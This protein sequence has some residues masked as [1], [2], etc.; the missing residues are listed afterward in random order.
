MELGPSAETIGERVVL[1]VENPELGVYSKPGGLT[2]QETT[3]FNH[4]P[5][6]PVFVRL[7]AVDTSGR[8]RATNIA[9]ARTAPESNDA[10]LIFAD[11]ETAGYSI[12]SHF[13]LS[14]ADPFAGTRSYEA[15]HTC[16]PMEEFC[17]EH[18]RRQAI[19]IDLSALGPDDLQSAFLEWSTQLTG[20]TSYYSSV[21]V[22]LGPPDGHQLYAREGF[23]LRGD[24]RYRTYQ[25]PLRDLVNPD[26]PLDYATLAD[27]LFEFG[28]GGTFAA[29]TT[30]RW[31]EVRLRF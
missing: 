31:D 4:T 6:S 11:E 25:W 9:E 15:T 14:D 5:D 19:G 1:S 13:A 8:T 10:V 22:M 26:R 21:R 27:G 20:P 23:T 3:T 17:W 28:V 18:Y 30:I 7:V 12:P 29:G 16:P 24:G 2:I